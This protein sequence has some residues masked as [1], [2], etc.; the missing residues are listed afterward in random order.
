MPAV[1]TP[2]PQ[3][4][5][6]VKEF[7]VSVSVLSVKVAIGVVAGTAVPSVAEVNTIWPPRLILADAV[8]VAVAVPGSLSATVTDSV[9]FPPVV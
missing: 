7:A 9:S 4:M 1:V 3:S 5:L 8:P 6:A 2:S